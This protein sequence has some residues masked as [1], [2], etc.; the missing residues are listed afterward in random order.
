MPLRVVFS[1]KR[2]QEIVNLYR[3]RGA[4]ADECAVINSA[5]H[6]RRVVME[7][8]ETAGGQLHLNALVECLGP[9]ID[10]ITFKAKQRLLWNATW[11]V[12][13]REIGSLAQWR[14]SDNTKKRRKHDLKRCTVR[15]IF[16][17]VM[18]RRKHFDQ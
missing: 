8:L 1:Q 16:N 15:T 14:N 3:F 7:Y 12:C 5:V 13:E 18:K 11:N 9:P 17:L 4:K 6:E 2:H 10:T